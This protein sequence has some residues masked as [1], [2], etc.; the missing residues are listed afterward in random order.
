[1]KEKTV[2]HTDTEQDNLA[3]AEEN[4][5]IAIALGY[6]APVFIGSTIWVASVTMVD[7]NGQTYQNGCGA[8]PTEAAARTAIRNWVVNQWYEMGSHPILEEEEGY[9]AEEDGTE[10]PMALS[11]N[12]ARWNDD[13]IIKEY[14]S[15]SED[16]YDI[17]RYVISSPPTPA[18]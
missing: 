4:I 13:A 16:Y 12:Y 5:R 18:L 17:D 11:I 7:L 14:F 15:M 8:Y 3:T 1:M 9:E 6:P 2:S 10:N